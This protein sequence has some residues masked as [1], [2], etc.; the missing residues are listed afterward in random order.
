MPAGN[1][2]KGRIGE[3]I[4]LGETAQYQFV[5]GGQTLKIFELNPRFADQAARGE[6]CAS[7]SPEDVV[8]LT[9]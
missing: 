8:V 7:V 9:E 3:C 5:A 1:A 4:Y 2:V 6:L